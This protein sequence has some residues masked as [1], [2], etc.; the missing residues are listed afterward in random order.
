MRRYIFKFVQRPAA[1]GTHAF[2]ADL[3]NRIPNCFPVSESCQAFG[4]L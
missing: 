3:I 1:A 4:N 2:S